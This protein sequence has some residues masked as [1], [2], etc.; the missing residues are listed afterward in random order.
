MDGLGAATTAAVRGPASLSEVAS[1]K[2]VKI[3]DSVAGGRGVTTAGGVGADIGGGG[4]LMDKAAARIDVNMAARAD[5]RDER[6]KTGRR[7]EGK[8]GGGRY[9]AAL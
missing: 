5:A 9:I 1:V 2:P 3:D 8:G 4:G 7:V 6:G